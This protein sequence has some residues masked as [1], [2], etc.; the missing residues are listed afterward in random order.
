MYKMFVYGT[1]MKRHSNHDF[2]KN[3]RFIGKGLLKGY[4]MYRVVISFPGIVKSSQIEDVVIGEVYE[5]DKKTLQNL[6]KLEGE[7]HMYKRVKENIILEDNK[8]LE[9]YVYEWVR[10]C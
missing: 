2:L 9:A 5:I 7:G 6:D 4:K 3:Q 10:Q 1:L 8:E